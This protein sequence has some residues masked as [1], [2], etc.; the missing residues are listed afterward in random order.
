MVL[1]I[2]HAVLEARQYCRD[3]RD[4][5]VTK[6][7]CLDD[8]LSNFEC[9]SKYSSQEFIYEKKEKGRIWTGF[10]GSGPDRPVGS[11]ASPTANEGV[12]ATPG[13]PIRWWSTAGGHRPRAGLHARERTLEQSG[14]VAR[15]SP[16]VFGVRRGW[17]SAAEVI[18]K[19]VRVQVTHMHE[20][21]RSRWC[22]G[23]RDELQQRVAMATATTWPGPNGGV[24]EIWTVNVSFANQRESG[25][26]D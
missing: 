4:I 18:Q 8:F 16:R 10:A 13:R 3:H 24:S 25:E 17:E 21:Q 23:H 15:G 20:L 14:R 22:R 6:F 2:I 19:E 5:W 7:R 26:N 12:R 1:K 9:C 11:P